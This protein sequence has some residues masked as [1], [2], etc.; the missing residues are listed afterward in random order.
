MIVLKTTDLAGS[1]GVK[2]CHSMKEEKEHCQHLLTIKALNGSMWCIMSRYGVHKT[3]AI[4]V[5][6]KL[7]RNGSQFVY[8]G[9]WP[10]D[11]ESNE[12]KLLIPYMRGVMDALRVA[13]EM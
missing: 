9:M 8:F 3:M 1:D 12:A 7:P 5:Y 11:L 10:I 2:L 13:H 6:N 4:W